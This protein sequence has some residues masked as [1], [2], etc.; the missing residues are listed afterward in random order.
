MPKNSLRALQNLFLITILVGCATGSKFP[1]EAAL[2]PAFLGTIG[3]LPPPTRNENAG[4]ELIRGADSI[5]GVNIDSV[6]VI[7]EVPLLLEIQAYKQLSGEK[8]YLFQNDVGLAYS[9]LDLAYSRGKSCFNVNVKSEKPT[10]FSDSDFL[11]YLEDAQRHLYRL[12]VADSGNRNTPQYVPGYTTTTSTIEYNALTGKNQTVYHDNEVPGYIAVKKT[13]SAIYCAPGKIDFSKPFNIYLS[14]N[15]L[16][17]ELGMT[18]LSWYPTGGTALSSEI[19]PAVQ[20]DLTDNPDFRFELAQFRQKEI[21][22][23]L[24][25]LKVGDYPLI[26]SAI[27]S[28][29]GEE[30]LSDRKNLGLLAMIDAKRGKACNSNFITSI[31]LKGALLDDRYFKQA[32][33]FEID[34]CAALNFIRFLQLPSHREAAFIRT[35]NDLSNSTRTVFKSISLPI[36]PEKKVELQNLVSFETSILTLLNQQCSVDHG[37]TCILYSRGNN[38]METIKSVLQKEIGKKRRTAIKENLDFLNKVFSITKSG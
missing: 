24:T 4:E 15:T 22:Y 2:D 31:V 36:A 27:K 17:P 30:T 3:N 11:I 26:L 25:A 35:N 19:V 9:N 38:E 20:K 28:G 37:K 7:P 13:Y 12:A 34:Q 1:R 14:S 8:D 21:D 6:E 29:P 32:K 18:R 33:D 16:R 5:P 23:F 10:G